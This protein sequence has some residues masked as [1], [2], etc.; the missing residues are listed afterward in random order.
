MEWNR[1]G[2]TLAAILASRIIEAKLTV[3]VT[4]NS[5]LEGWQAEIKNAFPDSQVFLKK[6]PENLGSLSSSAYLVLNYE[7]F[8]QEESEGHVQWLLDHHKIDFVILDEIHNAKRRGQ[9]ET[10]R[11]N[12]LRYLLSIE[13]QRNSRFC[14]LGMSATPVIIV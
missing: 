1:A 2:K 9:L 12:L 11:R 5:T 3:I 8:Q 6:I 4:V 7:A 10:K 13:R 14:V